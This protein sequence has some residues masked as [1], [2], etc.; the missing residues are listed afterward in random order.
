M[1]FILVEL[2][3]KEIISLYN[4]FISKNFCEEKG[5]RELLI[6]KNSIT[7]L[8]AK[9]SYT[10][11]GLY[12]ETGKVYCFG[13]FFKKGEWLL[14]DYFFVLKKYRGFNYEKIFFTTLKKAD[15]SVA[16][17]FFEL[18]KE[19]ED[20]FLFLKKFGAYRTDI[21]SKIPEIEYNIIYLPI[22]KKIDRI[23]IKAKIF[24]IYKEIIPNFD[25]IA[26]LIEDITEVIESI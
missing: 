7:T 17:I 13:Y 3:K 21:V 23:D 9:D 12:D 18:S 1:K 24:K 22:N 15:I 16:G 14:L 5:N 2:G 10:G 6:S 19:R 4:R 8:I 11:Y 20:E 26:N 25:K